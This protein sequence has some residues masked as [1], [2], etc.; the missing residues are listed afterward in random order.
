M[1]EVSLPDGVF[2][3]WTD[4]YS[5]YKPLSP[6]ITK[7][8]ANHGKWLNSQGPTGGKRADLTGA[9][10]TGAD[11]GNADLSNANLSGADLSNAD[12]SNADLSNAD[13]NYADLTGADLSGA[14]LNDAIGLE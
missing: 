3:N 1:T 14:D 9:N 4:T 2:I 5:Q 8:L 11:L 12:L 13:L 10:L 6:E 7:I